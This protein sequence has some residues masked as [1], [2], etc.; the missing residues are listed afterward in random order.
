MFDIETTGLDPFNDRVIGIGLKSGSFEKIVVSENEEEILKW[1]WE[2]MRNFKIEL[3][4]GW[5]IVRFDLWFIM[6]R[7]IKHEIKIGNSFRTLDLM[8]V[9]FPN[10]QRWKRLEDV[11]ETFLGERKSR[12]GQMIQE[13][14]LKKE[15]D[16]IKE[17]L[18]NDVVLVLK[19]YEKLRK[20]G[21][22]D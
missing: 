1:F 4:I 15:F 14:F 20:S 6:I 19:L 21:L 13:A 11:S 9:L 18:L 16:K 5:N 10:G 2:T 3:L 8:N 7:C 17:Y 12:S 22:V